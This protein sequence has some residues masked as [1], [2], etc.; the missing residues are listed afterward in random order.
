MRND[1]DGYLAGAPGYNLPLAALAN[2]F[3]AQRYATVATGDPATP[4]GLETAF[5]AAER[6]TLAAAVLARCDALDGA[7]DGLVQ[8]TRACQRASTSCATCPPA[9][10][11]ATA[12]A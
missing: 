7:S 1:Y 8:D 2:I 4:P 12:A 11:R 6:K 5:T 3:G 9:P 10:A